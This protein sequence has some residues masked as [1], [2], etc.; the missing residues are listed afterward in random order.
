MCARHSRGRS[1]V[2]R[3]E[4]YPAN[5][6]NNRRRTDFERTIARIGEMDQR[7]LLLP[8]RNRYAQHAAA[9]DSTRGSRMEKAVVRPARAQNRQRRAREIA[10]ARPA[11]GGTLGSNLTLGIAGTRSAASATNVAR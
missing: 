5:R 11:A 10:K 8:D 2:Q 6:S 9:S 1:G 3:S 4:R 7:L